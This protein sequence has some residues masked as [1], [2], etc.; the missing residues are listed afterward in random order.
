[1]ERLGLKR[2]FI[3][4]KKF[5]LPFHAQGRIFLIC[6]VIPILIFQIYANVIEPTIMTM[7]SLKAK[8]IGIMVIEEVIGE[9]M[10]NVT[11]SD[12]IT[13]EKDENGKILALRANVIEMN[14]MA[15]TISLKMQDRFNTINEI[16]IKIPL[17]DFTANALL[18]GRGP[19]IPVKIIPVGT[20]EADFKSEFASTGINQ[21]RHRIYL[22]IVSN[23]S[24]VAPL[25]TEEIPIV[26]NINVAETV[27]IGDVPDSFYNLEG[28]TDITS[29][30]SLNLW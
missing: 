13:L 17:G 11:Y 8:S 19:G 10:K 6:V 5:K 2:K 21:I 18:A 29:D 7:S 4:M 30:D 1:M 9:V 20:V 27:I 3:Q 15:A 16:E 23:V 26:S 28:V 25:L 14:R 22:Q 12:L 24:I